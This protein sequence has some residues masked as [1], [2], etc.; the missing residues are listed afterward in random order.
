MFT[1]R[2]CGNS[3]NQTYYKALDLVQGTKDEFDYVECSECGCVQLKELITDLSKYYDEDYYSFK[4]PRKKNF[5][6]DNPLK[7][8]LLGKRAEAYLG[9]KN[10]FGNFL[11]SFTKP[12]KILKKFDGLNI[13]R[14]SSVLDI[15]CGKKARILNKL[16]SE[17]F[18]DLQGADPF[19]KEDITFS[20][21]VKL[22]KKSIE[23]MPTDKLYDFIVLS[24]TLEHVDNPVEILTELSKRLTP[25][26]LAII[27]IPMI[28]NPWKE[29]K[30]F[31]TGVHAPHHISLHTM[32]SM[33]IVVSKTPLKINDIKFISV[34][35]V[36]WGSELFK[37]GY[38]L[39]EF[40]RNDSLIKKYFTPEQLKAFD[41]K[42][43]ED[44]RNKQGDTAVYI[45][46]KKHSQ[47]S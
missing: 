41:E 42:A 43:L 30:T 37:K 23:D 35:A 27:D 6:R 2:I 12:P 34:G 16:A 19:L 22:Y 15:G 44:N 39:P 47:K 18:T 14:N 20:N 45:L 11:L 33:E 32:K 24:H 29:Y 7:R 21:G 8:F 46:K 9:N 26:G 10:F 4:K 1:C 5:L 38:T 25:N 13:S 3:Q 36:Y 17:G 28:G 31:W 40:K